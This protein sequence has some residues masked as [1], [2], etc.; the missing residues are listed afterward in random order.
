MFVS[1]DGNHG[2]RSGFPP[3]EESSQ[4]SSM[5][6]APASQY[7]ILLVDDDQGTRQL[8]QDILEKHTDVIIVGQ[9]ADGQ[10]A[11]AMAIEHRPD[12]ILMDIG[13]PHLDGI[14]AT[15][16]IKSA[17]PQTVVIC[18]TGDFS[19]PKYSAMRTAGAAAF[20]CKNQVLAIHETI[21]HAIGQ[22]TSWGPA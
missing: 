17:C 2:T 18:L 21:M 20:V 11:V 15:Q 5:G 14:E 13:L 6:D 12:V 1:V 9:A 16:C 3:Q 4:R 10:E 19:P 7:R 22:W 8:L